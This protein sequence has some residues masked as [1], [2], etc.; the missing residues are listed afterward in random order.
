MSHYEFEEA[1][2]AKNLAR[3]SRNQKPEDPPLTSPPSRGREERGPA[4]GLKGVSSN[5]EHH[6]KFAQAERIFKDSSTKV[7][8]EISSGGGIQECRRLIPMRMS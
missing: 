3:L 2:T 6:Q 5:D 7:A 1:Q 4:I 8:K